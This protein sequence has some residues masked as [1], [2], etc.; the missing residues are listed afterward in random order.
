MDGKVDEESDTK[1]ADS[2]VLADPY[3]NSDRHELEWNR[4]NKVATIKL[5]FKG[6]MKNSTKF[7]PNSYPV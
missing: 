6:G 4:E 7:L 3:K 1:V 2:R 5:H